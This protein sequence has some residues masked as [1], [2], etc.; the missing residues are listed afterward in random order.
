M[1]NC[2][3]TREVATGN[4]F[5]IISASSIKYFGL[6]NNPMAISKTTNEK[7]AGSYRISIRTL[8]RKEYYLTKETFNYN[9]ISLLM[10][11]LEAK[12]GFIKHKERHLQIIEK[13]SDDD[14]LFFKDIFKKD[15][16][17]DAEKLQ[18]T[19]ENI[20]NILNKSIF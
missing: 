15:F 11:L 19:L 8:D 9:A 5:K 7:K 3:I 17:V 4:V 18:N 16:L 6:I 13:L 14:K 20:E 10:E 1:F 2:K 12:L